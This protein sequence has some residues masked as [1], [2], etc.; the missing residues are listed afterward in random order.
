MRCFLYS[1]DLGTYC[2]DGLF[3]GFVNFGTPRW[4]CKFWKSAGWAKRAAERMGLRKYT[5]VHVYP[6]DTV[7]SDGHVERKL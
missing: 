3:R 5:I 7:H 4:T 6:G 2:K 1:D